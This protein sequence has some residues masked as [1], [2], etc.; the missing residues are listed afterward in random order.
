MVVRRFHTGWLV[1]ASV[2]DGAPA[3][4][5]DRAPVPAV[6]GRATLSGQ[7]N[8]GRA[9]ADFSLARGLGGYVHAVAGLLH[10][11]TEATAYEV[12][13]T[14]T[15]YLAL[16]ERSPGHPDHDLMLVWTERQGWALAVETAPAEPPAMLAYLGADLVPEPREV[17]RFVND[18]LADPSGAACVRPRV[19]TSRQ[20]VGTRL[21]QYAPTRC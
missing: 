13:D 17:V 6:A 4:T 10:I 12:S 20:D 2:P 21:A 14:A 3:A 5:S 9:E 7:G 18:V 15:A 11:S 8:D 1:P 19:V 16:S